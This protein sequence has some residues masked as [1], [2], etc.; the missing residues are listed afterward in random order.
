MKKIIAIAAIAA[1]ALSLAMLSGCSTS[2]TSDVHYDDAD[3]YSAGDAEFADKVEK[4]AINY[5]AGDI[6]IEQTDGSKVTVKETAEKDLDEDEMIH[7]WLD[8][9]VL[10]IQYCAS[11]KKIGINGLEKKLTV[12]VPKNVELSDI[13]IDSGAGNVTF[14]RIVTSNMDIDLGAGDLDLIFTKVPKDADID[15]GAGDITITMPEDSNIT[16]D[17]DKGLGEI[18][19]DIPFVNNKDDEEIVIG[20]GSNSLSID[21]G[22]GDIAIKKL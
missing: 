9:K 15:L 11:D 14:D 19:S 5:A 16:I 7:T 8:G 10:R 21:M 20:D 12:S 13:E 22:A 18:K 3:K 4:I 2:T 17:T 1:L 6:R